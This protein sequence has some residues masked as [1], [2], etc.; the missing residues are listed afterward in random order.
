MLHNLI[1]TMANLTDRLPKNVPGRYYVDSSCIDC[2][3]CRTEAPE[4][5][6]RDE[7]TGTSILCRQPVTPEEIE[8]V[9][10]I[11]TDCATCSIGNDGA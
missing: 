7:E 4:F 10:Q 3:Q 8:L 2:D 1:P 9:E 5:F 6:V 11:A